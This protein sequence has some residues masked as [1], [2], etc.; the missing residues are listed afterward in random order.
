[1]WL[2]Y[3]SNIYKFG[4]AFNRKNIVKLNICVVVS[5]LQIFI[6]GIPKIN[7]SFECYLLFV[8]KVV[9]FYHET[10]PIFKSSKKNA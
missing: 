4:A 6:L 7:V 1:M 9:D 5:T 8:F 3:C 2:F 10:M